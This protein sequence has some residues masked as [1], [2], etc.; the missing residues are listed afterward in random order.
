MSF[1]RRSRSSGILIPSCPE[2]FPHRRSPPGE[3]NA[4]SGSARPR[5]A[6]RTCRR[7]ARSRGRPAMP[8]SP[9]PTGRGRSWGVPKVSSLDPAAAIPSSRRAGSRITPFPSSWRRRQAPGGPATPSNEGLASP[10][11]RKTEAVAASSTRD[12]LASASTSGRKCLA[13]TA[14]QGPDIF[15]VSAEEELR[16]RRRRRW[17]R[18]QW[19]GEVSCFY[20]PRESGGGNWPGLSATGPA[21]YQHL[22]LHRG[23]RTLPRM[24]GDASRTPRPSTPQQRASFPPR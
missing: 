17:F 9:P 4:F 7:R 3:A 19:S 12:S 20:L 21:S 24:F 13:S 2:A 23:R 22:P 1:R 8:G 11:R 14:R 15:A 10:P 16:G 18:R 6:P 5:S